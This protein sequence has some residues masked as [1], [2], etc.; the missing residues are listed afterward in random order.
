M[1]IFAS[2]QDLDGGLDGF[3]LSTG[4]V[5]GH[6]QEFDGLLVVPGQ[7]I[8]APGHEAILLLLVVDPDALVVGHKLLFPRLQLDPITIKIAATRV[9]SGV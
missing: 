5:G 4:G 7:G 8:E 6:Q 2:G 9:K 3:P 1:F